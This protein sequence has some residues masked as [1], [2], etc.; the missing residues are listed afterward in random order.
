MACDVSI[1]HFL[2]PCSKDK[3]RPPLE[4]RLEAG[5]SMDEV[6]VEVADICGISPVATTLFAFKQVS[7][8]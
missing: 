7:N 1:D 5:T 8:H 4:L 3:E 2:P 6:M